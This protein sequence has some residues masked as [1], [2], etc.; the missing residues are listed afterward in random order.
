MNFDKL[1]NMVNR[2]MQNRTYMMI[3]LV[4][5]FIALIHFCFN[6][7][8]KGINRITYIIIFIILPPVAPFYY[9]IKSL[10]L[11]QF[12]PKAEVK[13]EK[14]NPLLLSSEEAL[15]KAK[16]NAQNFKKKKKK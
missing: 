10:A 4:L 14:E 7:R 3:C 5:W 2:M 8:I 6:K 16:L 1:I 11:K 9:V 15:E 12:H 13:E